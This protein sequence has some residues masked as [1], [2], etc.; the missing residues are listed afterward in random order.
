MDPRS[1]SLVTLGHSAPN[2]N[3]R[4]VISNGISVSHRVTD[5]QI[6][7]VNGQQI[8]VPLQLVRNPETDECAIHVLSLE[9]ESDVTPNAD[10]KNDATL[11]IKHEKK[12]ETPGEDL[13]TLRFEE[14]NH[15]STPAIHMNGLNDTILAGNL[16]TKPVHGLT[17]NLVEDMSTQ[18][19]MVDEMNTALQ[20]QREDPAPKNVIRKIETIK[21]TND[22][23]PCQNTKISATALNYMGPKKKPEIEIHKEVHD[24]SHLEPHEKPHNET[25]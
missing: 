5:L 8:Q 15:T 2:N 1:G 18:T 4:D 3:T 12:E 10:V 20:T 14:P 24:E 16:T 17:P 6:L 9:V 13:S 22:T 7:D 25:Y 11:L 23:K 19:P 21:K